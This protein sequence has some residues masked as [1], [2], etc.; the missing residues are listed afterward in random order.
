VCNATAAKKDRSV[1]LRARQTWLH[2]IRAAAG[3]AVFNKLFKMNCSDTTQSQMMAVKEIR[4]VSVQQ[5]DRHFV[6]TF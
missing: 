3:P 4:H 6:S 2:R 1:H 5:H